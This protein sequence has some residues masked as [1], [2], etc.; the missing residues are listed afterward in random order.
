MKNIPFE[1]LSEKLRIVHGSVYKNFNKLS[2]CE[3]HM[4]AEI[5]LLYMNSGTI[6]YSTESDT[7]FANEGDFVFINSK[8]PHMSEIA[9]NG[10][11]STFIQFREPSLYDSSNYLTKFLKKT[12]AP[13]YLFKKGAP[14]TDELSSYFFKMIAEYDNKDFGYE[15]Y[16]TATMYMII[17][18]LHRK[19]LISA[20]DD[21]KEKNSFIRKIMPALEYIENNYTERISLGD[22]SRILHLNEQYICRLFKKALGG[23]FIDYLNFVRI[24]ESEKLL[25]TQMSISSVAEQTGFSTLAYFEKVFKKHKLCSP[26]T[27]RQLHR[28]MN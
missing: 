28:E 5:E 20:S 1:P 2:L 10:T 16:L 3:I 23:S 26:M 25:N 4:H 21:Q 13:F 8:I 24:Y 12:D 22:L 15:N 14:D 7:F 11:S 19:K 27:Y 18:F 17:A 9:E 6:K